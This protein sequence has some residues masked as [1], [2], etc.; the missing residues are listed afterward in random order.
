MIMILPLHF[1]I[2]LLINVTF[3][4]GHDLSSNEILCICC[5]NLRL[6]MTIKSA[7]CIFFRYNHNLP[8]YAV[9]GIGAPAEHLP[10]GAVV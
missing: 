10:G 8:L 7:F 9:A 4:S 5:V 2:E 6:L 1:S 3:P